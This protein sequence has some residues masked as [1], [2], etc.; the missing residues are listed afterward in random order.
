MTAD[1]W[2]QK[3]NLEEHPE[4]GYYRETYRSSHNF[5]PSGKKSAFPDGR[6]YST[7][8]YYL[9]KGPQVSAFH[10]IKSD[11][12][13]HFH[14][15][16]SATIHM[17]HP[18]ALYEAKYLGNDPESHQ[19]LQVT[20]PAG[21]WFGVT[22]DDRERFILTSCTV[23]PGFDFRDFELADPYKLKKAFPEHLEIIEQLS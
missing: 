6:P 18:D 10:R 1:Q 13:W 23:A 5:P 21:S 4:G 15:G 9:L 7:A 3:L 19:D 2:I 16:S 22:V 12:I 11:E 14:A 17:I 8:I 20:V